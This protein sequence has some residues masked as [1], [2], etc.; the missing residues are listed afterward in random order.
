MTLTG[1]QLQNDQ[2]TLGLQELQSSQ[3][4]V[5]PAFVLSIAA[6]T[7]RLE[8]AVASSELFQQFAFKRARELKRVGFRGLL[9]RHTC[10]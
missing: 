7:R 2:Q 6:V 1:N 10:L 3:Y 4:F 8:A 9:L 5:A